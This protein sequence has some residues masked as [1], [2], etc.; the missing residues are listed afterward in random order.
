MSKQKLSLQDQLLKSGLVSSA[1]AKS[2]KSDK[3]KQTEQQR[4]NNVTVVDEAKELVQKTQAEK[5]K[6]DRELN[7]LIKQQEEQ[8]HLIA[9][10]KQLIELNKQPKDADGLAY[11]FNDKNKVKT[12][13][14][15]ETIREQIIR[16][17][18]AIVKLEESYEA[19]SSEVAKK[20][21]LRDAAS[22]I[23]HNEPSASAVDTKDDPYADY[24][25][26]DDLMW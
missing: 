16:G 17:R 4:K 25:I 5:A 13:Y 14:V 3:R 9:Q 23:V 19:V 18:L 15:S 7:Q 26:P 11:H 20:I 12:L 1:Q 2:A 24:Q 6:R 8:K 10:V 21:S 22:V